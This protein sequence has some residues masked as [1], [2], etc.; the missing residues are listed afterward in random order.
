MVITRNYFLIFILLFNYALG[1]QRSKVITEADAINPLIGTPAKG[2]GGTMPSVGP[3]FALTNFTAQTRENKMKAM[4]Y[5]YEDTTIH[6]FIATHQP[7]VWMGDY[8]YV[9]VMPQVGKLGVLPEQ[10][11]MK[12]SHQEEIS[13]AYSYSVKMQSQQGS[14]IKA[15]LAA[16]EKCGIMKFTYPASK[17]SHLIIQG[18][19][20]NTKEDDMQNKSDKRAKLKG[21]I[22]VDTLRQEIGGYNP[23][24]TAY[25]LGP[26]LPNFKGYFVIKFSKAIK[27]YGPG[28][29]MPFFKRILK[30]MAKE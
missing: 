18:I 30:N 3:P 1:Q 27:D 2:K 24:R 8:G 5:V 22:Y 11:K 25:N 19:N 21:Y 23:D 9:S 29:K 17:E 16:S 6:G 20:V 4:P 13:K 15:E 12:F 14:F 7:T 10:R 26:E 28:L